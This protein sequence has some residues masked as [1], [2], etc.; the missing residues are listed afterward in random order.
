MSF[1]Q[2]GKFVKKSLSLD[3]SLAHFRNLVYTTQGAKVGGLENG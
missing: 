2:I 3:F 1:I